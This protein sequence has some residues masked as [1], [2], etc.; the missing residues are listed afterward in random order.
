MFPNTRQIFPDKQAEMRTAPLSDTRVRVAT[1]LPKCR[2]D[3]SLLK[4]DFTAPG[5]E[6]GRGRQFNEQPLWLFKGV[7]RLLSFL[8]S[9]HWLKVSQR[10]YSRSWSPSFWAVLAP[11]PAPAVP[12]LFVRYPSFPRWCWGCRPVFALHWTSWALV[13]KTTRHKTVR[14][15][16]EGARFPLKQG[17]RDVCWR[18]LSNVCRFGGQSKGQM[19]CLI[20]ANLDVS[21]LNQSRVCKLCAVNQ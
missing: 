18:Q 10:F 16:C 19:G 2:R 6:T 7:L 14:N 13:L 9:W 8:T 17:Y 11:A 15:G 1:F 21:E 3:S 20:N 5:H 12:I 4:Y